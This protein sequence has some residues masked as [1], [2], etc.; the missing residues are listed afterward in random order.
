M[1]PRPFK[2]IGVCQHEPY[3]EYTGPAAGPLATTA[4][5]TNWS[6][7]IDLAAVQYTQVSAAWTVPTVTGST[8]SYMSIWVGFDG[9]NGRYYGRAG[10]HICIQ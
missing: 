9:Y 4:S 5:S 2:K 7:V 6:G 8:V 3:A 1:I 10:R